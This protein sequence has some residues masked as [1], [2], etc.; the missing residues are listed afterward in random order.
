MKKAAEVKISEQLKLQAEL[1]KVKVTEIFK[2]KN[3]QRFAL[4]DSKSCTSQPV[5]AL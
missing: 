4:K 5:I 2:M 3:V 1:V